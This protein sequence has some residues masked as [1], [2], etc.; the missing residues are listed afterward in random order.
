[1]QHYH[2][3]PSAGAAPSERLLLA[4]ISFGTAH[5]RDAADP[6]RIVVGTPPLDACCREF[7]SLAAGPV[8]SGWSGDIGYVLGDGFLF[9]HLLVAE[10][11]GADLTQLA[12]QAYGRLLAFVRSS[13]CPELLRIWNYLARI[14]DQDN[15][16]ERYQA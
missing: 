5:R 4:D 9:A 15:G 14:N 8:S 16:I 1:M 7:W 11:T 12:H 2:A 13:P 6:R 10:P 3:E